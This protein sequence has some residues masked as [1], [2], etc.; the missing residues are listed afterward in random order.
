MTASLV[1]KF[2][3]SSATLDRI[4]QA[5]VTILYSALVVRIWPDSFSIENF[6]SL[7][8]LVSEGA[9]VAFLLIRRPTA[10]ISI[11][12]ADWLVAAAGT[13]LPLLV[14]KGGAPLFLAGG[15]MLMIAGTFVHIGAKF[16]LN[17][18]FGLVAANRGIKQH[19]LYRFV[20]HPMYAGYM[21]THIGFMTAQPSLRNGLIYLA[22]WTFLVLRIRAE[23]RILMQD[24]DYKTFASKVRYRLLPGVY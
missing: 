17:R 16:S 15:G 1:R 4:E 7:L 24:P 12:P 13:F 9:V 14:A 6:F 8:L 20:R 18:S 23:E 3:V 10:N 21:L 2:A 11:A 5:V 22:V 19:G